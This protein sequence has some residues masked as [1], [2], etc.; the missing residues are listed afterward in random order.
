MGITTDDVTGKPNYNQAQTMSII[1][2]FILVCSHH[3][4]IYVLLVNMQNFVKAD[5]KKKGCFMAQLHALCGCFFV[6]PTQDVEERLARARKAN[7]LHEIPAP[8]S[9]KGNELK[10]VL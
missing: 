9:A 3:L 10:N 2:M 5:A 1:R 6:K 8:T 7:G 4:A